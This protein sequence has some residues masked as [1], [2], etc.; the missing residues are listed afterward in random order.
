MTPSKPLTSESQMPRRQLSPHDQLTRHG[1]LG[2]DVME[3]RPSPRRIYLSPC[4]SVPSDVSGGRHGNRRRRC[5]ADGDSSAPGSAFQARQAEISAT[6]MAGSQHRLGFNCG[7]RFVY[8][9]VLKRSGGSSTN[10]RSAPRTQHRGENDTATRR[11]VVR[12]HGSGLPM[13]RWAVGALSGLPLSATGGSCTCTRARGRCS[14]TTM[15]Q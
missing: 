9:F 1:C 6:E 12:A 8:A 11:T 13:R 2:G 14:P 5:G 15:H 10:T 3:S 7:R 4:V